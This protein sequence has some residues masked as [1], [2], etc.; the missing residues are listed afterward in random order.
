MMDP[1]HTLGFPPC[2]LCGRSNFDLASP[3]MVL[4]C[5]ELHVNIE[6]V[7]A[8][9]LVIALVK[10]KARLLISIWRGRDQDLAR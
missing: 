1:Y 2:S 4:L 10:L 6:D 9:I 5:D 3:D 7:A 8:E